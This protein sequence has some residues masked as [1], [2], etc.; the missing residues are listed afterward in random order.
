MY[1]TTVRLIGGLFQ[2]ENF[3][4]GTSLYKILLLLT[5]TDAAYHVFSGPAWRCS[6]LLEDCAKQS[7]SAILVTAPPL[8]FLTGDAPTS[9]T[10]SA[11]SW[12][13]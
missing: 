9:M 6:Q 8:R 10:K 13:Q 3:A 5:A 12:Q 1:C 11:A 4:T 2:G 7:L